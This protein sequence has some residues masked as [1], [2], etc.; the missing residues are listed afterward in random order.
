MRHPLA[1]FIVGA[2]LV[3]LGAPAVLAEGVQ[4][5]PSTFEQYR[6]GMAEFEA[7]KLEAARQLLEELD[8]MQLP[9][10]ERRIFYKALK[11]IDLAQQWPREDEPTVDAM[12][13][14]APVDP[15]SVQAD[16]QAGDAVYD[17]ALDGELD[18]SDDASPIEP[19]RPAQP[20]FADLIAKADGILEY[21]PT[22]AAVLYRQVL[23]SEVD[24]PLKLLAHARLAQAKRLID[25]Q[26]TNA[27]REL[28]LAGVDFEAGHLEAAQSR[29][30]S[31]RQSGISLGW[32]D[33]QR[34]E[35]QL[36]M[37]QQQLASR[38]MAEPIETV[39]VGDTS[40]E[41]TAST[42]FAEKVEPDVESGV[43][44]ATE[45]AE[46]S[47][48]D[49]IAE[50][51][52]E[53]SS[54]PEPGADV[55]SVSIEADIFSEPAAEDV[56]VQTR[57]LRAQQAFAAGQEANANSEWHLAE[58]HYN[59][60]T[61]LDPSNTQYRTT[62]E[63]IQVRL[64]QGMAPTSVLGE[65]I[66]VRDLKRQATIALFNEHLT[67]TQ[68]FATSGNFPA[69]L[70][71]AAQ[72]KVV[73]DNNKK[74][75][76]A[77]EY[78]GLRGQAE[79]L[80]AQIFERQLKQ[81]AKDLVALEEETAK[82]QE[83]A[84]REARRKKDKDVQHLL[85]RARELQKDMKYEDAL[86][87]LHQALFIDPTNL[88]T[89][90]M[91]EMIEDTELILLWRESNRRKNLGVTQN[92]AMMVE[93]TTPY[94]DLI[95]YPA[96]WPQLT[97]RRLEGLDPAGGET[98]I[99]RNVARLLKAPVPIK[100]ENNA[101]VNVI[102]Y[103][104]NTTT[105]NFFVNWA[106]LE[107]VGVDQDTPISLSLS[108]VP[109]DQALRLVLQQAGAG[110]EFDPIGFSII[111]GVVEISTARDLEKTTDTRVY[112]IR[113]LLV[114]VPNFGNAPAFDLNEALSNTNSGGSGG[115]GGGGGG[116][117]SSI[118]GDDDQDD[119][120]IQSRAQ[121]V[122]QITILVQDT[123]GRQDEW[124]AYGG[125]VSSIQELNGNF[126]VKTTPKNH[127][128]IRDLLTQLRETR[129][130]QISVEARFLLVAEDFLEDIGVD[131]DIQ[132]NDVGT[133]F[134]PIKIAQDSIS[135]VGGG[136]QPDPGF[137]IPGSGFSPQRGRALD[138]GVTY[139]D[140]LEVNLLIRATQNSQRSITLTA[141]R[142]TFFNGQRAYVMV[143]RQIRNESSGSFRSQTPRV[144]R[145][146]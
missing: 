114:Q 34:I 112:D 124:A 89:Q 40:D 141:P 74:V 130:V 108:N 59:S 113:D 54:D 5:R 102:D 57:L 65:M 63:Q 117:D 98:D 132:M 88:A 49:I 32:F 94:Q 109:A 20:A 137:F 139:L 10:E 129:A 15:D 125:D 107:A 61:R 58:K 140:D 8:P 70:D 51:Y 55:E 64:G 35:R 106:S 33:Q 6:L 134:A 133:G 4:P 99:N 131:L 26:V 13:Q 2:A 19:V 9:Q 30:I 68:R 25:A 118:F 28:D 69:A 126:I 93:A 78:S 101:L 18:S 14:T 110:L 85:R 12:A 67:D 82:D 77:S 75:L 116:G 84:E 66:R 100:F 105:A 120:M 121:L 143:A 44:V 50:S 136:L 38:A 37:V 92:R 71:E 43:L 144:L 23:D 48:V 76:S 7:G 103:L 3:Y 27:R 138:L 46:N 135:L 111:D 73:L 104:H 122:D 145:Q 36:A 72:A 52:E 39:Q 97:Q 60:A 41:P 62:L 115:G 119:E 45:T 86:Q 11:Q 47:S 31:V 128:Q 1:V 56:L 142:V 127:R 79:T 90:A 29:L 24:E 95:L 80:S 21:R 16:L 146:S 22:D 53:M 81:Q 123:V 17:P 96:D 83:E 42:E 87:V 91:K